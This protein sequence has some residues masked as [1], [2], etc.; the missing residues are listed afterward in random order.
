MDS[1]ILDKIGQEAMYMQLAEEAAELSQ[2]A[3]K[4]ARYLHGTNPVAK[5]K[6]EIMWDIVEE[7]ADVINCAR[8][9]EVPINEKII[10]EKNARWRWRLGIE[11][12]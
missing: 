4:M 10:S 2:A 7:Y 1:D 12:K 8:H 9:L 3:A 5:E 6:Y 11:E